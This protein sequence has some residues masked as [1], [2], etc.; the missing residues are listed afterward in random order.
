MPSSFFCKSTAANVWKSV[1]SVSAAGKKR[2]RG[3]GTGRVIAKD[4]NRGQQIGVGRHKLIL[5]GLNTSVFAAK[6]P[7]EIQD[8][9]KNDEFQEKLQ[10]VRNEMNT[11]RKFRELPIERGFSGRRAHGRHAGQPDDHNE[12]SFDGFDSIVLMLRPIQNMTGVMGR[13]KS[14]QALVVAGNK[15]GLAGFGM[16]SG[17][18]GRAVVRHARNR[19]AQALVYIPRFEGHTVMHDFFSRYYQTTVFV[20]R[21]PRGHGIN[22]HRVIKAICEM[23]G[24]TDLYANVEGVTRNQINMTKAFFLGLMNQKSYQD[25]ANEKQLHLVDVR[26]ENYFYPQILASPEGP[27]KTD[28]D[29][30]KSGENLDFTYYI[31]DGRVKLVTPKRK[32]FYE[33]DATWYKHLDRLDYG[34]NREKTKLIL[35]AKY[36]STK[37]LDVFPHFKTNAASFNRDDT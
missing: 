30:A 26:E 15:N 13:T 20:E 2:G 7:V 1:I 34:K 19:A 5:P 3:K 31:N 32:P 11:F 36:G 8:L 4:F 21:K 24:I 14:M 23:F 10:A 18:D 27:V 35:A 29:I 17:K 6:K 25:I 22:A 33:G 16:A 12:T 28:S 37:V 9:G